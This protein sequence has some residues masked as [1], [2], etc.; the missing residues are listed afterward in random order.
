M[1]P[2]AVVEDLDPL[3]D[4]IA[5]VSAVPL[6]L[7]EIE[8]YLEGGKEALHCGIVPA[9][10]FSTQA[11]ERGRS[12]R[13]RGVPCEAEEGDIARPP[14]PSTSSL[15]VPVPLLA[16]GPTVRPTPGDAASGTDDTA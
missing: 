15:S 8:F 5:C 12:T 16:S 9:F 14:R 1:A 2:L 3:E 6:C 7:V 4:Q 10:S 13:Q 11:L